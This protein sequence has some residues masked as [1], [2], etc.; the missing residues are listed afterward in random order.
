MTEEN[1]TKTEKAGK[2]KTN[3]Y[4]EWGKAIVIAVLLALI[5]R[6]FLFEPYLVEGSSMYPTLHD[7]ERL[8]VN[9]TVHYIGELERGDIVII[10]G[11]TSKIHYVKRLIGKPGETVEM[12]DDTLYI[13]GKKVAEPYLSKNKKEAEKLGVSLTGD[14]GPVK[15][16][17]G[18][19]FVMGDNRLNS[20]DSRN[21]LGLIA[22]DRIVG[23]SKF[24]FFPFNEMRQTK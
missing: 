23:T 18:K 13:N 19:Y 21:G 8:F 16:P 12:K 15:V 5:I 24:V 9:K 1:Q 3:T 14:F 11:E 10:N 2:K 6:H 22:E 17:K 4:W 7:G 20:M